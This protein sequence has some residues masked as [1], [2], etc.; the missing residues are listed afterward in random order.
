MS[1]RPDPVRRARRLR[2]APATAPD[3]RRTVTV[4]VFGA[5]ASGLVV[6]APLASGGLLD[7]VAATAAGT[8]Q[9]SLRGLRPASAWLHGLIAWGGVIAY[10]LPGVALFG[11]VALWMATTHSVGADTREAA[12]WGLVAAMSAYILAA[13]VL[14]SAAVVEYAVRRRPGGMF[15][16]TGLIHRLVMRA[17][18]RAAWL[19]TVGL[20]GLALLV[21]VLAW[22]MLP[23]PPLAAVMLGSV[24]LFLASVP[25]AFIWGSV[26]HDAYGLLACVPDA[27]A[28]APSRTPAASSPRP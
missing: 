2:D 15:D 1:S 14:A 13:S 27:D 21:T 7:V 12:S 3:F 8:P 25:A 18:F 28:P 11:G 23:L 22:R 10:L 6:T 20:L 9:R 19:R 5:V 24:T 4:V 16:I 17:P 26:A